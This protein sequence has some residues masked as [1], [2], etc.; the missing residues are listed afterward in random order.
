MRREVQVVI[1]GVEETFGGGIH[2][3]AEW[4]QCQGA[5]ELLKNAQLLR[6]R[7]LAAVDNAAL[8]VVGESFYQF[9]SNGVTGTVLLAESHLAIHT[10]PEF[11]TVTVDVFVCN[12]T[13]DTRAKAHTL[14]LELRDA[15]KPRKENFSQVVR[16]AVVA[17]AAVAAE[18]VH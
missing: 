17:P 4:Y 7:C 1:G 13:R 3:L 2:L 12:R 15:L 8:T 10:W 6:A 5:P 9:A 16:G 18:G 11:G 14:Y